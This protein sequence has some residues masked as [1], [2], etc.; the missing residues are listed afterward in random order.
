MIPMTNEVI[1]RSTMPIRK[2]LVVLNYNVAAH[3]ARQIELLASL[4]DVGIFFV[5][6]ASRAE[7]CATLERACRA[8]GG[9]VYPGEPETLDHF[10]AS[11][12]QR[13]QRLLLC[14]NGE[15]LGYSGGNNTALRVLHRLLGPS[16]EYLIL[17]PDV[18]VKPDV[19]QALLESE[20]ESAGPAIYEQWA[21]RVTTQDALAVDF[22]TGFVTDR[23]RRSG[24]IS[25][26]HGCCLKLS[27]RALAK[28]GFLP[29]ENFLYEEELCY[30]ERVHR[31]GG[32]P[33][34]LEHLQVEHIG[35]ASTTK[36]SY[37][38]FYY[39]FR[40]KLCYFKEV[41]GPVYG[42]HLAFVWLY[43]RWVVEVVWYQA[44]RSNW[45]GVRGLL[46]GV[47]HGLQGKSG[48]FVPARGQ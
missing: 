16:A 3:S 17:N 23:V 22:A 39:I 46:H 42:G 36:L 40:N 30:F 44:R 41:G 4:P 10:V 2:W 6:N 34:Y 5:D 38:Y 29:D 24:R 13:G 12:L 28:Y 35:K 47:W 37:L 31:L 7:D 21:K 27:G 15:N 19:A 11:H 33:E 9:E 26:L 32:K 14:R 25:V 48:R 18:Y 43:S 45:D 8:A 20:A 1:G